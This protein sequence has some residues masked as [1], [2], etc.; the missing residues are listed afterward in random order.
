MGGVIY[1]LGVGCL[2][3][4]AYIAGLRRINRPEQESGYERY[5]MSIADR[6]SQLDHISG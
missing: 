3:A 2:A 6:Q 1:F 5:R 4:V